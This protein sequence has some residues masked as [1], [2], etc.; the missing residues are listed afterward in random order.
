M[1]L[2]AFTAPMDRIGHGNISPVEQDRMDQ[3][4]ERQNKPHAN[5][6]I[7]GRGEHA[8][9]PEIFPTQEKAIDNMTD[10]TS[11]IVPLESMTKD[12]LVA[13]AEVKGIKVAK[14]WKKDR[15]IAAFA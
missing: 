7:D 5:Y 2:Q 4:R 10:H 9:I 1:A 3:E 13:L 12:E 8:P 11:E 15:I 6:H 14:S